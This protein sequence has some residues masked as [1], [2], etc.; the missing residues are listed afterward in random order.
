M[1]RQT[2]GKELPSV[3]Y[4]ITEYFGRLQREGRSIVPTDSLSHV[5]YG[6]ERCNVCKA[7]KWFNC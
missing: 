1:D 5:L 7:S 6:M 3:T 2:L 4:R